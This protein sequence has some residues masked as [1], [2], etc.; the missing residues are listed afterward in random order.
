MGPGPDTLSYQFCLNLS[1]ESGLSVGSSQEQDQSSCHQDIVDTQQLGRA[2]LPK[3]S[4]GKQ[5]VWEADD[6]QVPTWKK[7]L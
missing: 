6:R 5:K 4:P 1:G 2:P 7:G 3:D